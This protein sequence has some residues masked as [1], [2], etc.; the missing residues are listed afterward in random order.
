MQFLLAKLVRA[1]RKSDLDRFENVAIQILTGFN[2]TLYSLKADKELKKKQMKALRRLLGGASK[3]KLTWRGCTSSFFINL[4]TKVLLM[5]KVYPA[6]TDMRLARAIDMV[7]SNIS[8]ERDSFG[9]VEWDFKFYFHRALLRNVMAYGDADLFEND[10]VFLREAYRNMPDLG[11]ILVKV[12][13]TKLICQPNLMSTS[14]TYSELFK[15]YYSVLRGA[16]FDKTG[17]LTEDLI[18]RLLCGDAKVFEDYVAVRAIDLPFYLHRL[19]GMV[20]KA[21]LRDNGKIIANSDFRNQVKEMLTRDPR[22]FTIFLFATH[23][24]QDEHFGWVKNRLHLLD[25]SLPEWSAPF[26]VK[27]HLSIS[28]NFCDEIKHLVCRT[29]TQLAVETL[30][31]FWALSP[32]KLAGLPEDRLEIFLRE[33]AFCSIHTQA[34][35]EGPYPN[36]LIVKD[37]DDDRAKT[38]KGLLMGKVYL[39]PMARMVWGD[40]GVLDDTIRNR[41]RNLILD[42]V[43]LSLWSEFEDPNRPFLKLEWSPVLKYFRDLSSNAGDAEIVASDPDNP[44]QLFD[45]YLIRA[46]E[47][48]HFFDNR[49][50]MIPDHLIF[51]DPN[52]ERYAG[53]DLRRLR[54]L[55]GLHLRSALEGA[56]RYPIREYRQR[57]DLI[58]EKTNQW[59]ENL[60]I[61]GV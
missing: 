32:E 35:W 41:I 2:T 36:W 19:F 48:T 16:S 22:S 11:C 46:I 25:Y 12:L 44:D 52:F 47:N 61:S 38:M 23:D 55:R 10:T 42:R 18:T 49:W 57:M 30:R 24:S 29:P 31:S 7:Q 13:I 50:Y 28:R 1:L 6:Q 3:L 17:N 20:G 26:G 58:L 4:F 54:A 5:K 56:L 43:F 15:V 21:C 33:G 60:S 40:G 45:A 51:D 53:T 34:N 59:W 14:N 39:K 27:L 37:D 8:R 9:E